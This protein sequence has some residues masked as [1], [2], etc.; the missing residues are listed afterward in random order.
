[1]VL[2]AFAAHPRYRRSKI[3]RGAAELYKSRFFRADVYSSRRAPHYWTKFQHPCWWPN[4]LTGLDALSRVG[5]SKADPD[6]RRGLDWFRDH[7]L[8]DGV[9]KLG[10][11]ARR[12]GREK[13]AREKETQRWVCLAACVVLQRF[14]G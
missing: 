1:M 6:V 10:Y 14:Y 2:R 3:A 8:K 9:W 11:E 13:R 12:A 7:Q 4:I 5:F